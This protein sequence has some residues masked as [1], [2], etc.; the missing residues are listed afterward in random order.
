MQDAPFSQACENNKAPILD[1]LH[2]VFK[3]ASQALEIGSGTGQHAV[4]FAPQLPH[5]IWQPSDRECNIP[6]INY[7]LERQPASNLRSPIILDV[8]Q[9]IWPYADAIFSANTAH[10]MSWPLVEKTFAQVGSTLPS[11]G[12]FA[13]YGP[14][15]YKGTYTSDSNKMFDHM[16]KERGLNQGIRDFEAVNA[17]AEAAKLKLMEDNPMPANNRLLVW[18]KN[19]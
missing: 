19:V 6:G 3:D 8:S 7:W 15:N 16:L 13:L 11:G 17:L 4:H 18:E 5:L 10:I 1:V 9:D 2:R 12:T 14:F